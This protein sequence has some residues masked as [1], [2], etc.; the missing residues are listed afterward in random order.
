MMDLQNYD[1][2]SILSP[3]VVSAYC[4]RGRDDYLNPAQK[5]AFIRVQRIQNWLKQYSA[6]RMRTR[7]PFSVRR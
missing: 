6:I 5:R 7:R 4:L 1:T 2:P 3:E